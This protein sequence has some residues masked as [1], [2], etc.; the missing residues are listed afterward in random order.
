[1]KKFAFAMAVIIAMP[2]PAR[3]G[4]PVLDYSNLLQNILS[5]AQDFNTAITTAQQ[6]VTQYKQ[7]EIAIA[8]AR[9]DVNGMQNFVVSVFA[10]LYHGFPFG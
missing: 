2:P 5:Y 10:C 8:H 1:M 3:A 7:L 6:L 9:H 4:I